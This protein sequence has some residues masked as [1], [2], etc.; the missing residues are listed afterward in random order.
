MSV[1]KIRK[2]ILMII[3]QQE[4]SSIN[5]LSETNEFQKIELTNHETTVSKGLMAESIKYLKDKNIATEALIRPRLG[6]Y[7]FNDLEV[8]IMEAD[9]FEAQALGLD[10]VAIGATTKQNKLDED[11]MYQLIG[12]SG[13]MQIT[14]NHVFDTLKLQDQKKAIDF[15]NENQIDHI[16]IKAD[17]NNKAF[18]TKIQDLINYNQ[19]TVQFIL[20]GTNQEKLEKMCHDLDIKLMLIEK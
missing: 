13:G 12:A 1:L 16:M 20:T 9:I 11:V 10:S 8:K 2:D 3:K 6:N 15:A 17:F 14:L 5:E 4:I 7:N 19:G 18:K